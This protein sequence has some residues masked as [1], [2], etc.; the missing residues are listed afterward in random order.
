MMGRL[1]VMKSYRYGCYFLK[2]GRMR[3]SMERTFLMINWIKPII[4]YTFV[5]IKV[6]YNT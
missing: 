6:L 4:F 3:R 1:K 5:P 2:K